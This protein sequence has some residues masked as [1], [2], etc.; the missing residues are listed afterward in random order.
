MP[1]RSR[2]FRRRRN[3]V[4]GKVFTITSNRC[5]VHILGEDHIDGTKESLPPVNKLL[6][7]FD[8]FH[9][10]KPMA[11]FGQTQ[12]TQHILNK[13][14]GAFRRSRIQPD[15]LSASATFCD[16]REACHVLKDP[17]LEHVIERSASENPRILQQYLQY[18]TSRL[19]N[20]PRAVQERFVD[21][22]E[23]LP[24]KEQQ[25]FFKLFRK[26]KEETSSLANF[27]RHL[28][29]H[30]GNV[31]SDTDIVWA[32]YSIAPQKM[33][34][35]FFVLN[36]LACRDVPVIGVLCGFEHVAS[37]Q[38]LLLPFGYE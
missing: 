6:V 29:K 26:Y 22:L 7:E 5:T 13:I 35:F 17:G 20:P 37:L 19:F 36:I 32:L 34:D 24:S 28:Y 15:K 10:D 8:I 9:K 23:K 12:K 25:L 21:L 30:Y 1:V 18:R 27:E 2:S 3:P 33:T 38:S 31:A 11:P 14:D 4:L 16:V